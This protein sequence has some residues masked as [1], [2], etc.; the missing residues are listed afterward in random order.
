MSTPGPSEHIDDADFEDIDRPPV[1][2][3]VGEDDATDVRIGTDNRRKLTIGF[4]VLVV[5]VL[6]VAVASGGKKPHNPGPVAVVTTGT[7]KTAVPVTTP[8]TKTTPAP[9]TDQDKA[10]A[11]RALTYAQDAVWA[12]QRHYQLVDTPQ[13]LQAALVTYE[14]QHYTVVGGNPTPFAGSQVGQVSVAFAN[15]LGYL[16]LRTGY[17]GIGL[18]LLDHVKL[19]KLNRLLVPSDGMFD[20]GRSTLNSSGRKVLAEVLA[21]ISSPTTVECVGYTDS[22]GSKPS[23]Y[24]LGAARA[25]TVCDDLRSSGLNATFTY[26]SGGESDPVASNKTAQ[27]R[28]RNRRVVLNLTY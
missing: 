25:Q 4:I 12:A 22:Q 2:D 28:A 26:A 5:L 9:P 13:A 20:T 6:I 18:P 1:F 14:H 17:G 11:Q 24:R 23:N 7:V 19:L 16:L 3:A 15:Q 21:Q 27:G 10:N 8:T